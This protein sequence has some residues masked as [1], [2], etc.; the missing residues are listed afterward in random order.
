MPRPHPAP[1]PDWGQAL[2][3]SFALNER[4]NQL[5][6]EHLDPRAWRTK[7]TDGKG[8]GIAAIFSHMQNIRRKWLRLSAPHLKPPPALDRS[9]CSQKQAAEA[10]AESA[11]RC[12]EMLSEALRPAGRVKAFLRDGWA[13]PWPPGAA[14]LA[15]MITHDAHHRGQVC[16]LAR[17]LG[18]P[19]RGKSAYGVWAWESLAKE[20]GIAR[21]R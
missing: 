5:L 12:C 21:L 7:P 11:E 15:Y 20:C 4:M 19:L 18:Y 16:M 2:A 17:Q 8:R 14:M 6:L 13:R 3:E 9:R 10:L 1:A